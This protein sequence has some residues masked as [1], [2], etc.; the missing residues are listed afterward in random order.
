MRS[1]NYTL[2][3]VLIK[4]NTTIFFSY[5]TRN[6]NAR[7]SEIRSK[8]NLWRKMLGVILK[9]FFCYCR[10]LKMSWLEHFPRFL[11]RGCGIRMSRV[12][13]FIKIVK[14]GGGTS[15]RD[16]RVC[17]T[18]CLFQRFLRMLLLNVMRRN[19]FSQIH[20]EICCPCASLSCLINKIVFSRV[21]K[22]KDFKIN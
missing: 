8:D 5:S 6:Y 19:S 21:Q 14:Q 13:T 2:L 22:F 15:I 12:K 10:D 18:V 16:L 4:Q 1:F 7:T 9:G 11:K 17:F 20:C 3:F